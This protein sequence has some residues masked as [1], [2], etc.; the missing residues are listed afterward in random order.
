MPLTMCK[1]GIKDKQSEN[2]DAKG[3]RESVLNFIPWPRVVGT[4]LLIKN[5]LVRLAGTV[6]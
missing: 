1:K 4:L 2:G 6:R 5:M 3:I